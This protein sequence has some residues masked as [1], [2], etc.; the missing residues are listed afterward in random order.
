LQ[1]HALSQIL[2]LSA[3]NLKPEVVEVLVDAEVHIFAIDKLL[4]SSFYKNI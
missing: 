2:S 1:H 4:F 3:S